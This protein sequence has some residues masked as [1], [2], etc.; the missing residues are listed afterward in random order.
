M[1]YFES[2]NYKF[3]KQEMKVFESI[4]KH[5]NDFTKI[6]IAEFAEKYSLNI[7]GISRTSK[8]MGAKNVSELKMMLKE[9]M[10][11]V[12]TDEKKYQNS[13]ALSQNKIYSDYRNTIEFN[14]NEITSKKITKIVR[15]IHKA[16]NIYIYG[17]GNS[18]FAAKNLEIYMSK[19]GIKSMLNFGDWFSNEVVQFIEEGDLII[20]FSE[21][22]NNKLTDEIRGIT[23]TNK[24][25][26]WMITHN[27]QVKGNAR[28]RVL[29]Y[30]FVE[31]SSEKKSLSS[32]IAQLLISDCIVDNV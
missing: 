2:K 8:K 22:G 12:S 29:Y 16:K 26:S 4:N 5:P 18:F 32:K 17:H 28:N 30:D 23:K 14:V 3:T 1:K 25:T 9:K 13:K 15:D 6:S 31:T 24:A 27:I 21:R 7:A 11:I 20:Q 10:V 19:R